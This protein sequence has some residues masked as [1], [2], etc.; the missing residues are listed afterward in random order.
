MFVWGNALESIRA[1]D[2]RDQF[3]S[4]SQVSVHGPRGSFPELSVLGPVESP[5]AS[6]TFRE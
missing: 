1:I 4:K 2:Q 3:V 6:G 5:N